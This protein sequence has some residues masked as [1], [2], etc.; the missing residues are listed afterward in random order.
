MGTSPDQQSQSMCQSYDHMI[1]IGGSYNYLW[2]TPQGFPTFQGN[3]GGAQFSYEYNKKN[4]FYGA[5]LFTYRQG[6][7]SHGTINRN[8]LDF[9]VLE[10]LGYT[11]AQDC[12]QGT[13]FSGFGFRYLQQNLKQ[14]AQTT[15][16]FEY[17]EFYIPVG[18][19]VSSEWADWA[20]VGL[21]FTW[22]P[23]VFPSLQINPF[24]GANWILS[25]R[26][27]NFIVEIP[28]TFYCSAYPNFTLEIT[29]S[30]EYWNDG[31]TTATTVGGGSLSVPSN[32]YQFLGVLV[33]FGGRF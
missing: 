20:S 3:L 12:W 14:P 11:Y 28:F 9:N 13:L 32:R 29:P 1:K 30:Y 23:Q 24:G 2:L 15:L 31:R 25:N 17:K 16:Y 21:D 19:L 18:F 7:S 10:R 27:D 33:N 4:F 22:M 26:I 6:P 5:A 8:I